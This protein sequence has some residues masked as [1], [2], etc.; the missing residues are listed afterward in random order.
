MTELGYGDDIYKLAMLSHR[1]RE[2]II[3]KLFVLPG[4]RSKFIE[5]FKVVDQVC[6]SYFNDFIALPKKHN[7]ENFRVSSTPEF[8]WSDRDD[9][10]RAF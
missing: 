2:D 4:H 7:H 9:S 1:Q 5:F 10:I 6:N 8:F 3:D